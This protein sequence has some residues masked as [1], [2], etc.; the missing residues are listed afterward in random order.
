MS[1]TAY[2]VLI[3]H[4]DSIGFIACSILA[5]VFFSRVI[6]RKNAARRHLPLTT[7]CTFLM[8]VVGV[9]LAVRADRNERTEIR[10]LLSGM[11]PTYAYELESLGHAML[12]AD[13]PATDPRYRGMIAHEKTW[14]RLNPAIA[15]IYTYRQLPD[16]RITIIVDSE[17]DLNHDGIHAGTHKARAPT[18]YHYEST[19]EGNKRAIIEFDHPMRTADG[20]IEATLRMVFSSETWNSQILYQRAQAL[21]ISFFVLFVILMSSTWIALMRI[22]VD[23]RHAIS[24]DL[25]AA[26][27]EAEK[28]NRAKSDFLANFS[29]EIRTPLNSIIGFGDLLLDTPLSPEQ[30]E[31]TVTLRKS[32]QALLS[33]LNNILDF[34]K[35]EANQTK[36]EAIPFS[37]TEIINDVASLLK[38]GIT[39][40]NL[41]FTIENRAGDIHLIGDPTR[42]RQVLT[43]LVHNAIKFTPKGCVT[44]RAE[45][46]NN[47]LRCDIIDTGI[48]I[49]PDKL[50]TLFH[51]F[52]QAEDSTTRHYGGTGLGL[53]ISRELVRLMGGTLTVESKPDAGT[54]FTVCLPASRHDAPALQDAAPPHTHHSILTIKPGTAGHI[55]L[56]EDNPTNR[57]LA[58]V[59]LVKLGYTVDMA[60][61]GHEAIARFAQTRYH[62]VLMD[63]EMPELDGFEAT[64]G[65]R[66]QE[67][68][69]G[70]PRVPIIAVTANV[71]KGT[72]QKCIDAGMDVYLTKPLRIGTI[73]DALASAL[74]NPADHDV[75]PS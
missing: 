35:I 34:S 42:I 10:R 31:Y 51:K 30:R 23:N 6:Q 69:K 41:T 43:N 19:N 47:S 65:I 73:R 67:K 15:D 16:G 75:P 22:D 20:R 2:P 58:S 12:T 68:I 4:L 1:T 29:H 72:Q 71:L 11:V 18:G 14:I 45:W 25:E 48:G 28:S 5:Y 32:G 64:R 66:N 60:V 55:L 24:L 46:S 44:L 39:D 52:S 56:V 8:I 53:V 63:C 36:L 74:R 59:M 13:T 61:N 50:K 54:T 27:Q 38:A 70:T 33:L 7:L 9:L 49:S 17:T 37:L 21:L 57:R 40:K 62:A 3:Y 26:K